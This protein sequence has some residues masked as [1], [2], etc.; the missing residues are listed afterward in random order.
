[1]KKII[2]ALVICLVS[3][4]TFSQERIGEY[5]MSFFDGKQYEILASEPKAEK[6]DIYIS[7]E[8]EHQYD[9]VKLSVANKDLEAFKS[10][11]LQVRDKYVEWEKKAKEN[12][13]K[14]THKDFPFSFK[15]V[16]VAWYGSKWWFAFKKT[17]TPVFFVFKNGDC[18]MVV[19]TK[20]TASSNEYIDQ[21]FY[22]V[23]KTED[24]FNQVIKYLDEKIVF[25]YYNNKG[26]TNDLFQ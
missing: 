13:V 26:K 9:D 2:S 23:L 4:T 16:D 25:D 18:A 17:F 15:N 19:S 5:N 11:L 14:D 22:F 10:T 1:M 8:G 7:V 24:E 12:N 21:K 20:V 3:T 6:F